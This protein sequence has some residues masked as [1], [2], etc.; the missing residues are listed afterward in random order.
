MV[1]KPRPIPIRFLPPDY[2]VRVGLKAKNVRLRVSV[3]KGLEIIVPK[4]FDLERIP[5]ILEK[6]QRWLEKTLNRIDEQRQYLA[7]KPFRDVP[8]SILL[9][10]IAQEWRVEYH[11]T[12]SQYVAA[13]EKPGNLL[14]VR[15]NI[16]DEIACIASLQ[17]W[18]ARKAHVHLVPWLK[19]ISEINALPFGQTL[20]KKQRTRWASCS[21]HKT[22]SLNHKLLFLPSHLVHYVFIHE[23]SH[24]INLNHSQKFWQFVATKEPHY[25]EL[26]TELRE[27]WHYVPAWMER[28]TQRSPAKITKI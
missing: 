17:R 26:D 24:T 13:V 18:V 6:K 22:I 11:P 25:Q 14:I 15:G 28:N 2:T 9:K 4:G 7:P 3:E 27:A 21:H 12:K 16:E 5:A 19:Q 10:A 1:N 20:L 23:L 8:E